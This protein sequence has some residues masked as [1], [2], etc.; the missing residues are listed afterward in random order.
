[1]GNFSSAVAADVEG[2]GITGASLCICW[3][4]MVVGEIR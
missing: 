3:F 4:I 2:D 1:L